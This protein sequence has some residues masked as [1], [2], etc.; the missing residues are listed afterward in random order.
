MIDPAVRPAVPTWLHWV[1]QDPMNQLWNFVQVA[2][3]N[4]A[5]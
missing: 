3:N 4:S 2:I 5:V 1:P